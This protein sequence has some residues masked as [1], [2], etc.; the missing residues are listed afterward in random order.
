[1]DLVK[2]AIFATLECQINGGMPNKR[3]GVRRFSY[4]NEKFPKVRIGGRWKGA[5]NDHLGQ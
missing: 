3:V 1:M 2:L 4:Q 5:K